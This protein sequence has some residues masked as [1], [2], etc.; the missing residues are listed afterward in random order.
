MP[1]AQ[2][3]ESTGR[4]LGA[5]ACY[6]AL[7]VAILT[8]GYARAYGHAA[9]Y[10]HVLRSLDARVRNYRDLA[11]HQAFESAIRNAHGRKVSFWNRVQ[12]R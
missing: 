1:L 12:P 6:R 5:V 4:L 9:D 3:L 2:L 11:T 10:L 7:L 8:R